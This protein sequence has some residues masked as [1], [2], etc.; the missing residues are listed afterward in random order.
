MSTSCALVTGASGYLGS[1]LVMH[2]LDNGWQVHVLLRAESSLLEL[3]AR[4]QAPSL[5][6]HRHDGSSEQLQELVRRAQPEVVFHLASLF[7]PQ[8]S[9][10]QIAPMLQANVTLGVQLL[11]AMSVCGVTRLVNA[12]TYWQHFGG[13]PYSP[14][15][16]YAATKQAF[17]V[18][19]QFYV[20]AHGLDVITL[21]LFDT[22][23][24][25]DPRR[26]LLRVLAEAQRSGAPLEMS[27]G[28]QMLDLLHVQDVVRAFE[29]GAQLLLQRQHAGHERYALRSGQARSLREVV[30]AYEAASACP[31][32]VRWGGRPYRPREMMRALCTDETL[33]GWQP[34]ISLEQGLKE[35]CQAMD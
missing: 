17:E 31:V 3:D 2:L 10:A 8:H 26:K 33:P 35:L 20:E 23:G 27:P 22:Y 28:E 25:G 7:V 16:L 14:V 18:L 12:G 21:K 9:T 24:P 1:R 32:P 6:L 11:D 15:N 29:H 19:A 5:Q 34:S 13:E 30:Q 4:L